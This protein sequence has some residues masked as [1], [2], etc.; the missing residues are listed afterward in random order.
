MIL[1]GAMVVLAVLL[2]TVLH[3]AVAFQGNWHKANFAL[4]KSKDAKMGAK[5]DS[6]DTE[7]ANTL[8]IAR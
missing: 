6:S 3:P 7:K 4:R 1:E 8:P 2:L 5:D